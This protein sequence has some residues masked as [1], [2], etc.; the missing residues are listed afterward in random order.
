M[1]FLLNRYGGI[2]ASVRCCTLVSPITLAIFGGH[3][4]LPQNSVVDCHNGRPGNADDDDDDDDDYLDD[5]DDDDDDYFGNIGPL[6]CF[7]AE[8]TSDHLESVRD[9]DDSSVEEL[10]EETI[11]ELGEGLDEMDDLVQQFCR[12]Q[13]ED[14][15][16]NSG[17]KYRRKMTKTEELCDLRIDEWILLRLD[18]NSS[19]SLFALRQKWQVKIR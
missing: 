17:C 19:Q 3:C 6:V 5:D 11:R 13:L 4:R 12:S 16:E 15:N 2:S 7:S 9:A 8:F 10:D 18:K 14:E 1:V